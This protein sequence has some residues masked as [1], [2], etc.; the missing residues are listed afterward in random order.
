MNKGAI[1]GG[2]SPPLQSSPGW[3][4]LLAYI[5]GSVDQELPDSPGF[6]VKSQTVDII[7]II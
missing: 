3:K 5:T 1:P 2:P 4:R 6:S 7:E